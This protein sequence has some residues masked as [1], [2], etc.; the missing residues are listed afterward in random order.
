MSSDFVVTVSPDGAIEW[1]GEWLSGAA[2]DVT[3]GLGHR[4]NRKDLVPKGEP[5]GQGDILSHN[6][7]PRRRV[8]A[9]ESAV[10][11]IIYLVGLI[12]IVMAILSFVGLG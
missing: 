1:N 10:S 3:T 11:S 9:W 5:F 7:A 12:V 8:N 6:I 4:E 2:P